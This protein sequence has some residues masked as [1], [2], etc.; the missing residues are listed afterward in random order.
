MSW[1]P[2]T[3]EELQQLDGE[4]VWF[5][6]IPD[7]KGEWGILRIIHLSKSWLIAVSGAQ[8]GFGDKD[9][10]GRTWLAYPAP[11]DEEPTQH[12][13]VTLAHIRPCRDCI[14]FSD[15]LPD[16]PTGPEDDLHWCDKH[17]IVLDGSCT[18]DRFKRY[19]KGY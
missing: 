7:E 1:K 10:Y 5:Y 8:R 3:L 19:L 15:N 4:S 2:F 14:Y 12:Q 11:P 6:S 9:T 16:L 18:C 17:E 13:L